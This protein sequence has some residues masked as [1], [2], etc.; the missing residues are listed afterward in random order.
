MTHR[1]AIK[2]EMINTFKAFSVF[3]TKYLLWLVVYITPI[4]SFL[5][6]IYI[7]LFFDLVTG[8]AKA[9]KKND[10]ITSKRMRDS[11]VKLI[12]Y[13][14]A[15][16][17]SYQVDRTLISDNGLILTK[18]TGGYIMLIE[19]QSNIENISSLTGVDIWMAVKDKIVHYFTNKLPTQEGIDARKIE[20]DKKPK[21]EFNP[22]DFPE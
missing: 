4:H 15:V 18:L 21:R 19:F 2:E 9:I 14:I 3:A 12:F 16:F 20:D 7:L 22:M 11:V 1:L 13:S 17:I 5:I 6:T 8:I 10:K